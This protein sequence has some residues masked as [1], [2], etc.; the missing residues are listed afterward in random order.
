MAQE[1]ELEVIAEVGN[2]REVLED[3]RDPFADEGT[4]TV[5]LDLDE[6]GNVDDLVDLAELP[7]FRLPYF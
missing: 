6:V 7:S 4:V 2:G 3:L 5:L 1:I